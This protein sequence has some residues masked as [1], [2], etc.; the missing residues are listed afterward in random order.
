MGLPLAGG[1]EPGAAVDHDGK[2]GDAALG[3][4]RVVLRK[5]PEPGRPMPAPGRR[6]ARQ[7]VVPTGRRMV[8][9]DASGRLAARDATGQQPG[10]SDEACPGKPW[11]PSRATD[12]PASAT[13]APAGPDGAPADGCRPNLAAFRRHA[14]LVRWRGVSMSIGG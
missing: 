12:E 5:M 4:D 3:L 2:G 6:R 11:N 1:G 7:P 9:A 8:E 13:A 14:A 10:L